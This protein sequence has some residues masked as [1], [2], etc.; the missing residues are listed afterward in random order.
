MKTLRTDFLKTLNIV[1]AALS[2]GSQLQEL[3]H[4]WFDGKFVYAYDE[5][6]GIRAPLE[7]D[8]TGGVRGDLLLGMLEKNSA[9]NLTIDLDDGELCVTAGSAIIKFTV[10]PFDN[11]KEIW[12]PKEPNWDESFQITEDFLKGIDLTLFSV[13]DSKVLNPEQ[14]GVTIIQKEESCIDFYTTDSKT[15]SWSRIPTKDFIFSSKRK[16]CVIL[17]SFCEQLTKVAD[18]GDSLSID[19]STV[20]FLT[21]ENVFVFSRL[22]E[23]S[24]DPADFEGY[25]K[26]YTDV[27]L[28][29]PVPGKLNLALERASLLTSKGTSELIPVEFN[30]TRRKKKEEEIPTLNIYAKTPYGEIDDDIELE[31]E[32]SKIKLN[33]DPS[34][35]KRALDGRT[36]LAI[37]EECIVLTG[38]DNFFHI[39][40]PN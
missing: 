9:K 15:I 38:P 22:V 2:S 30:I 25:M 39:I 16:R 33:A 8:F 40:A 18:K 36:R 27:D 21:K 35:F 4:L 26:N 34:L 24:E 7:T 5:I 6:L 31:G 17:T 14:R 13:G 23:E 28:Y 1:K 11:F 37:R 12:A 10:L 19:E 32:H 3:T 29:I 20:S